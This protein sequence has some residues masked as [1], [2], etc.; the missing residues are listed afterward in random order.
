MNHASTGV[1]PPAQQHSR[2]STKKKDPAPGVESS[3]ASIEVPMET[4]Q[5]SPSVAKSPTQLVK[6]HTTLPSEHKELA[7]EEEN[8]RPPKGTPTEAL[9]PD[10]SQVDNK[11]ST[12]RANS[13][14]TTR[15]EVKKPAHG[16]SGNLAP[17]AKRVHYELFGIP[18]SMAL[19]DTIDKNKDF[20]AQSLH[21]L[22]AVTTVPADW[23]IHISDDRADGL[24]RDTP[25]QNVGFVCFAKG[26]SKDSLGHW[27][28]IHVNL[29]RKSIDCYDSMHDLS[30]PLE[31]I[32][33]EGHVRVVALLAA[34][35]LIQN[36]DDWPAAI[37]TAKRSVRQVDS[38]NC[39]PLTW[40]ALEVRMGL[41]PPKTGS[42]ESIRQRL[43]VQVAKA[44]ENHKNIVVAASPD[45]LKITHVRAA[46]VDTIAQGTTVTT[47][48]ST[49]QSPTSGSRLRQKRRHSSIDLRKVKTSRREI[50]PDGYDDDDAAFVSDN[51][52][53]SSGSGI[54]VLSHQPRHITMSRLSST[55]AKA[56]EVL[57]AEDRKPDNRQ[58]DNRQQR[59]T[60]EEDALVLQLVAQ[61]ATQPDQNWDEIARS[62]PTRTPAAVIQR[63]YDLVE[64]ALASPT[65]PRKRWSAHE[66]QILLA[67]YVAV[68]TVRAWSPL[69]D[70]YLPSRNVNS[71]RCRLLRIRRAAP[72]S[73]LS[74]RW[75]FWTTDEDQRLIDLTDA[76]G[77]GPGN[78]LWTQLAHGRFPNRTGRALGIRRGI[79]EEELSNSGHILVPRLLKW[80][81]VDGITLRSMCPIGGS[82]NWSGI[83][84]EFFPKRRPDA[85][86][87]HYEAMSLT[88]H[89]PEQG[90][91]LNA[92]FRA[93]IPKS[94]RSITRDAA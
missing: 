77:Q 7:L 86:K 84:A 38:I 47:V 1:F 34:V 48:A 42:V 74:N 22:R 16:E 49:A 41:I 28:L 55:S 13:Q 27:F 26:K 12:H 32:H 94:T 5:P 56:C 46:V 9:P 37:M 19:F 57:P 93:D 52:D 50:A 87:D 72:S 76:A 6:P 59:W 25:V 3:D 29:Q 20:T 23:A 15:L 61:R 14:A 83:A 91:T 78:L 21:L 43:Y 54:T 73:I 51:T 11:F 33:L 79:L 2:W 58:S 68:R 62:F 90:L 8:H 44:F 75:H 31:Q 45:E 70:K 36:K 64:F 80:T 30:K 10:A 66:D 18:M 60:P 65:N 17:K 81:S 4:L 35:Q 67:L 88:T 53:D 89:D 85:L 71:T 39:G 69:I 92:I 63:H 40:T 24:K 82:P